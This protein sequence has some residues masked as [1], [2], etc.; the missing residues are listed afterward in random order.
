MY[1]V[2]SVKLNNLASSSAVD[3]YNLS[4]LVFQSANS[5]L[6]SSGLTGG[7]GGT[8]SGL[9]GLGSGPGGSTGGSGSGPGVG[10]SG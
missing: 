7:I 6:K 5:A 1:T 2:V 9:G 8:G 4:N 3:G 10:V